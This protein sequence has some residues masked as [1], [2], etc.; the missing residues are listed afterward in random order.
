MIRQ[1]AFP[2]GLNLVG[3]VPAARYDAAVK[4][5]SRVSTIA[6]RARSIAVI[7]NGGGE[8]WKAFKRHVDANP[9]W[10]ER[11]NP[12]DDFTRATVER[13]VGGM[14]AAQ[15]IAHETIYPFMSG[16]AT[17]NFMEAGRAA[18][19]SGPSILGVMV[20]PTYGPW[21]AFRAAIL[22]EEPIDAPGEALGFD[23]CPSCTARTC[24]SACPG[25]AVHFPQGWNIPKCLTHRVEVEADCA[26]RCHARAACVLGP[27][28]R[29]PE[30]ELAYHQGRALRS[31]RPYYDAHI[32]KR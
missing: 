8:F 16:G 11:D 17:L 21:I 19:L 29:Y 27:E 4:P 23:P 20:H 14:L 25:E 30:E 15:R 2:H 26:A 7:G 31:M 10:S 6:P 22:L 5:E 13:E 9:G 3:A 1:A 28:H 18:G 24:I 32:R 12:L